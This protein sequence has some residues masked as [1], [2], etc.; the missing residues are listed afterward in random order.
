MYILMT[1]MLSNVFL[2][3]EIN[4]VCSTFMEEILTEDIFMVSQNCEILQIS[5]DRNQS[6]K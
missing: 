6:Q 1:M 5:F 2:M 3:T 4:N